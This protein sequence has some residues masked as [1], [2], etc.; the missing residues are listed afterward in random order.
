MQRVPPPR[1]KPRMP[2]MGNIYSDVGGALV[3]GGET[4]QDVN[5][6]LGQEE[7]RRAKLDDLINKRKLAIRAQRSK[8]KFEQADVEYRQQLATQKEK[9]FTEMEA[10]RVSQEGR[11]KE[12]S[13]AELEEKQW[14][15]EARRD[16]S[17]E[18]F[19]REESTG[20]SLSRDQIRKMA[21]GWDLGD[22]WEKFAGDKPYRP[23][24]YVQRSGA[25][26]DAG[27]IAIP[28]RKEELDNLIA[29]FNAT[30]G[31]KFENSRFAEDPEKIEKKIRLLPADS[32]KRRT[33]QKKFAAIQ[34]AI[35]RVND[36]KI[37]AGRKYDED[38]STVDNSAE[39][40]EIQRRMAEKKKRLNSLRPFQ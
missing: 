28:Y 32:E 23:S 21:A 34:V 5:T 30:I 12:V 37:S 2:Q 36:A 31:T 7:S 3:S 29:D 14:R 16:F 8:E 13:D 25:K 1:G 24:S 18:I 27:E 33:L 11:L 26:K 40:A 10:R 39:L 6:K 17:K 4:I 22:E 15:R 38:D 9:E 19:N 20:K 35:R